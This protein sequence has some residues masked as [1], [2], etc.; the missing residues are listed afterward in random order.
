MHHG[1]IH[2][3]LTRSV[4]KRA[5][6]SIKRWIILHHLYGCF[7]RIQR[8]AAAHQDGPARVQGGTHADQMCVNFGVGNRPRTTMYD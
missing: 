5:D 6:T 4:E 1:C 2:F 7:A 8:R 3:D